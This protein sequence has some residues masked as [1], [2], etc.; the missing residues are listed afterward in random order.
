MVNPTYE[1]I[2]AKIMRECDLEDEVFI[3][4]DELMG[5]Y[6]DA[7]DEAE[8]EIHGIYEDYFL[9]S[10][11]LRLETGESLYSLPPDIYA[12]KIRRV[13]Y[14]NGADLLYEVQR[15]RDWKKFFQKAETDTFGQN[16]LFY[17][18]LLQNSS[19]DEGV[20]LVLVPKSRETSDANVLIWYIRNANRAVV[21]TDKC[22]I[23]EFLNFIYAH[24]RCSIRRKE[25]NGEVP[26]QDLAELEKQR[27]LMIDTLTNMVPDDQ[28]EVE[29]DL[30]HY[31]DHV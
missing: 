16:E 14:N 23:P 24:M 22:D 31:N 2:A 20:E 7:V 9:A 21:A 17:R 6:N 13:I 4:P 28:T 12:N 5:Y 29:Q 3:V 11:P 8:A 27:K 18:Y 26:G 15:I 25:F 19:A 1:E 30:S 10:K